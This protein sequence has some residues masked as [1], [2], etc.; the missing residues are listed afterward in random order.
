MAQLPVVPRGPPKT[1][2]QWSYVADVSLHIP[3][4]DGMGL[5]RLF[6]VARHVIE[7]ATN[8]P[9]PSRSGD[10]GAM[11]Q[12]HFIANHLPLIHRTVVP[13]GVP[14]LPTQALR[15]VPA[16]SVFEANLPA[17]GA[18]ANARAVPDAG[19][20]LPEEGGFAIAGGGPA[21]A[22]VGGA[23]GAL[24]AG[25]RP[26]VAVAGAVGQLTATGRDAFLGNLALTAALHA[27]QLRLQEMLL[28]AAALSG[29]AS[30]TA[31]QRTFYTMSSGDRELLHSHSTL[32]NSIIT[33]D[34]LRP[35][36]A[37]PAHAAPMVPAA[38]SPAAVALELPRSLS[39]YHAYC[40]VSSMRRVR[41]FGPQPFVSPLHF[42]PSSGRRLIFV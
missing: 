38:A 7:L 36:A 32:V 8:V 6:S 26:P 16:L 4:F 40:L 37:A 23:V 22:A 11:A 27:S 3:K 2:L 30:R 28:R 20:A 5:G 18:G 15:R 14:A 35:S 34:I 29:V 31:I 21:G 1:I 41:Y 9:F 17:A 10:G 39:P 19:A 33:G 13:P 42:L 12:I 25:L 24:G